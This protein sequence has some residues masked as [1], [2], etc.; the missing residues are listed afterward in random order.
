LNYFFPYQ[1][2]VNSTSTSNQNNSKPLLYS[3]EIKQ[4]IPHLLCETTTNKMATT[5]ETY[6]DFT[7][8]FSLDNKPHQEECVK[9]CVKCE[10]A[11]L[12]NHGGLIA[13][14]MGLGKT[15][16]II[17]LLH[18]NPNPN[19]LIV[20]PVALM[21]QWRQALERMPF[22]A[23]PTPNNSVFV[24]HGRHRHHIDI[25]RFITNTH[26]SPTTPLVVIT[27]Y[28]EI[29]AYGNGRNQPP[30][31]PL[32]QVTWSRVVFDEAHHLRNPD[33]NVHKASLL[34][35]SK[36]KWLLTGT[37]IQ[38]SVR[39][40]HALCRIIN[41]PEYLYM[42]E[43]PN[44]KQL[45]REYIIKR[46]KRQLEILMPKLS[47]QT[48]KVDWENE[49]ERNVASQLHGGY[50]KQT[51][52]RVVFPRFKQHMVEMMRARQMCILPS[53]LNTM[54]QRGRW[55][56]S[57]EDEVYEAEQHDDETDNQI[58]EEQRELLE[59]ATRGSSK[60]DA[61]IRHIVNNKRDKSKERSPRMLV[62]CEF[63]KEIDYI[64]NALMEQGIMTGRID[65]K[66]PQKMK[67]AFLN[68]DII[69]VL[70]LQV[71]TCSEG[72]N[73]QKYTDVYIVT[74]HWNPCVEAQAIGRAYRMGQTKDVNVYR[75]VMDNKSLNIDNTMDM[76]V[77]K[78]QEEKY[79]EAKA[80]LN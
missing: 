39:D 29:A 38:N 71:K 63:R 27:T 22:N 68:S 47:E 1:P 18:I 10:T 14:E 48:I 70:I 16:Q 49:D 40:F 80:V 66:I 77:L 44:L 24:Y 5:I 20:V 19:T 73:L 43:K 36:I 69:E 41:I 56:G 30:T 6:A 46:T 33:T 25:Q 7:T 21:E 74:P 2:Y 28:G 12:T 65:G 42:G 54:I 58:S 75:F 78:R 37:P 26:T 13:D 34:L 51:N 31:S 59:K 60:M 52:T 45:T 9:W 79:E 23:L 8:A 55:V 35:N 32:H 50:L 3:I 4:N 53:L 57:A 72:L 11:T 17:A 64:E 76:R 15:I 67:E 62:F 61:V